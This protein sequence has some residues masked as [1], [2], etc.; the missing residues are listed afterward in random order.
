MKNYYFFLLLMVPLCGISQS[1][2]LEGA[3]KLSG[4]FDMYYQEKEGKLFLHVPASRLDQ[5]FLYIHSLTSGLGNNDIGLDRGQL[6]EERLVYFTKAG[7]QILLIQPNSKFRADTENVLE[8]KSVEQAFAKSVLF[9]FSIEETLGDKGWLIDLTPFMLRDAHGV[10]KTLKSKNQGQYSLDKTRSA[11][12][13]ERT[14][15]FPKNIEFEALLTFSGEAKGTWVKE[16]GPD[17]DLLTVIQHHSFVE[18]P[19]PGFEMRP[20]DVRTSSQLFSYYDYASPVS[21]PLVQRFIRRHRLEKKDPSA[22]I[23]EPVEP[24]VYYL[25]NGTPEPVRSALLEGTKWWNQAFE[26]IGYKN[27]FRVE[28]LPEDADPL[29]VRYNV[30]Q[31]VHRSTRGWSYG[32]SVSDPRT[33][34]IIKGHVS[35]GSLR[36]RQDYLIASALAEAPFKESDTVT[37]P[38]LNIALARIRQ[39]A[40][41]EVGHTLGFSHNFAASTNVDASVMDYPHPNYALEGDL[42]VMDQT[43]DEGIGEWDKI[44]VAYAYQDYPE[45]IDEWKELDQLLTKATQEGYRYI[46]DADARAQGGSHPFAHLWDNGQSAVAQLQDVLK[47]RSH[48]IQR[49]STSNIRSQQTLAELEDAL[50]PLYFYHRYQ[51]EAAVKLLGG[52]Q[53]S[54]ANRGMAS[55]HPA[56]IPSKTQEEA[57]DVLLQTL[58]PET[59][60]FPES[61]VSL[62]PPRPPGYA[63]GRESFAGKTAWSFDQLSAATSAAAPVLQLI[64][65]PQRANRLVQQKEVFGVGPGLDEVLSNMSKKLFTSYRASYDNTIAQQVQWLYVD[66]L[67]QLYQHKNIFPQVQAFCHSHLETLAKSL[68]EKKNSAF[69]QMLKV[70]ITRFLEDPEDIEITPAPSIPDGAPIGSCG[71]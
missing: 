63:R 57:L 30:I 2:A 18:L 65:H 14:K 36:I 67:F 24:I 38:M 35:L 8:K 12:W 13:M 10:I 15:A 47:L 69:D 48:A 20:Y 26:A 46:T 43:Y 17:P 70:R 19:E 29:D 16:V 54:Y 53:Y 1:P 52:V 4:Y 66:H 21:E 41:H 27:A 25:D 33:G 50:V 40:A 3:S 60:A 31:W 55:N 23:S 32:A 11:V 58:T 5:E 7:K 42:I 49:F 22:K 68:S 37:Q 62:F 59:L 9:G 45:G 51:S 39:L 28:M 44:S 61:L 64:L 56:P 71:F 34:E 6:G